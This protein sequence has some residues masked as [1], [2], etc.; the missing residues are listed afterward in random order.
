[1][2]KQKRAREGTEILNYFLNPKVEVLDEK[3]KEAVLKKF[4]ITEDKLPKIRKTDPLAR[5]LDLKEG[6]VIKIIRDDGTGEYVY[7]RI[8]V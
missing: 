2:V 3:E 4:N 1:M 5:A 8:C 7:Y 6:Q